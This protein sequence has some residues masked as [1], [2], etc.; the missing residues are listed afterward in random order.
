MPVI[1]GRYHMNPAMGQALA[2]ARALLEG[3]SGENDDSRSAEIRSGDDSDDLPRGRAHSDERD[4]RGAIQRI[5]IECGDD[6]A[7]SKGASGGYTAYVHRSDPN[8]GTDVGI[9]AD[10]A[11]RP[12]KL[13]YGVQAPAPTTHVF[14]DSDALTDFLRRALG[15]L[16]QP[17]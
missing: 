2:A 4:S 11:P 1:N 15:E 6:A 7:P 5:E 3:K 10:T 17:A 14:S 8:A 12:G 9:D 16:S 13:P